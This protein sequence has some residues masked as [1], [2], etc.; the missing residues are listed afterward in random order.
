MRELP[1]AGLDDA[2]AKLDCD[3]VPRVRHV[4]TE[5]ERVQQA[6]D[7]LRTSD[8]TSLGR[9]MTASHLSLRDEYEVSSEEL[10]VAVDAALSAGAIGARMTG[11]GFGG[12]AIALLEE[13]QA[14]AVAAAVED[15]FAARGF[16]EPSMLT[17]TAGSGAE[18]AS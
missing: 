6:V 17:A 11:A 1:S 4:V 3:V 7:A 9:L 18:R 15:A 5:I 12:S 14:A 8:W 13:A 10:D 16:R 2:L